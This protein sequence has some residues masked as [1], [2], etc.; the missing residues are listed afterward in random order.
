MYAD[1]TRAP[2]TL[3]QR[4]ANASGP[5]TTDGGRA[6]SPIHAFAVGLYRGGLSR[7]TPARWVTIP[8]RNH[9]AGAVKHYRWRLIFRTIGTAIYYSVVLLGLMAFVAFLI[10]FGPM[11]SN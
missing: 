1:D 5:Q 4:G 11:V 10:Y 9:R 2:E 8:R 3:G 6:F 7:P